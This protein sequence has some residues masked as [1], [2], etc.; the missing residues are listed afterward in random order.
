MSYLLEQGE[1]LEAI[2]NEYSLAVG[3]L[4]APLVM[5]GISVV[6]YM[7]TEDF[8]VPAALWMLVGYVLQDYMPPEAL[9]IAQAMFVVGLA[10]FILSV[11]FGRREIG[12]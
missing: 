11:W 1:I 12:Y 5:F 7:R 3:P 10:A 2:A 6:I 9:S 4:L 8:M